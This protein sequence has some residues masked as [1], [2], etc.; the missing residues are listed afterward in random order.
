MLVIRKDHPPL[1]VRNGFEPFQITLLIGL[2]MW[3]GTMLAALAVVQG[4]TAAAFPK[5]AVYL[6]FGA[7]TAGT[8]TTLLGVLLEVTRKNRARSVANYLLGWYIERAGLTALIGLS[9]GYSVW[10]LS[11]VDV[12]GLPFAY[13]MFPVWCGGAWRCLRI[14]ADIKPVKSP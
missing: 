4:A 1:E 5:W 10:V 13:L 3:G 6:F 8:A 14:R 12:R 2:L 9:L 11:V 7:M